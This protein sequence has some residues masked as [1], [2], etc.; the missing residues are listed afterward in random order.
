MK[1]FQEQ[2]AGM[3]L[4]TFDPA[5]FV[6]GEE[7][8]QELCNF[9]LALALIYNDYKNLTYASLKLRESKPK[10][11]AEKMLSGEHMVGWMYTSIDS[12]LDWF[13]SYSI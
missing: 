6:G 3:R 5:A 4:E 12:S 11:E 9:V 13:M 10:G 1:T 7:V 8:P 2:C